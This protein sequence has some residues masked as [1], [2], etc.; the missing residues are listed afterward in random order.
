VA[1]I[2]L[3]ILLRHAGNAIPVKAIANPTYPSSSI[4]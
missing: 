3:P 1:L 4:S 2:P